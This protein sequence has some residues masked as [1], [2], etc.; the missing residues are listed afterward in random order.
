MNI[1]TLPVSGNPAETFPAGAY[2]AD[3]MQARGWTAG[4]LAT[5]T[6][7]KLSTITGI[8]DGTVLVIPSTSARL[9]EAFGT[10]E[11][12][13]LRLDHAHRVA[14]KAPQAP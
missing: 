11:G 12:L 7:M 4:H 14:V 2:L 6:R 8:I 10:S 9:S 1:R 3:E 5:I 13:W